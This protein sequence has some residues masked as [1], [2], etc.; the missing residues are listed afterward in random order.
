[1]K[2]TAKMVM[3][4]SL[5]EE[6]RMQYSALYGLKNGNAS[7]DE[8]AAEMDDMQK[9]V[10]R[11]DRAFGK[12]YDNETGELVKIAVKTL[13]SMREMAKS[14]LNGE[15]EAN[16]RMIGQAMEHAYSVLYSLSNMQTALARF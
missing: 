5:G 13:A 9:T 7:E 10:M 15:A 12:V 16:S 14:V 1:M 8:L 11:I 2:N 3:L 4:E 6:L